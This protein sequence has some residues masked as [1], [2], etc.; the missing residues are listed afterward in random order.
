MPEFG[1]KDKRPRKIYSTGES[2]WYKEKQNMSKSPVSFIPAGHLSYERTLH[3]L[4]MHGDD[5][6]LYYLFL[7]LG[8]TDT[9]EAWGIS[10]DRRT[11]RCAIVDAETGMLVASKFRDEPRLVFEREVGQM[12]LMDEQGRIAFVS[13]DLKFDLG[14][15]IRESTL[16]Q[17]AEEAILTAYEEHLKRI[18]ADKRD[19]LQKALM[20]ELLMTD[21]PRT[22]HTGTVS[23]RV[24]YRDT[25]LV[26]HTERTPST[27]SHHYG[28]CLSEYVFVASVPMAEKPSFIALIM[29]EGIDLE[30]ATLGPEIHLPIGYLIRTDEDGKSKLSPLVVDADRLGP[31]RFDIGS[32]FF[33]KTL[34]IEVKN[35][36]GSS[37][38][39]DGKLP[40]RSLFGH[41]T[42]HSQA[43]LGAL[44]LAKDERYNA[45]MIDI[46]GHFLVE[47]GRII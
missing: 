41:V 9:N 40:T 18:D 43:W 36:L 44:G 7:G 11:L 31:E 32:N 16:L 25:P 14:V 17:K 22:E 2:L 13:E 27:V 20:L 10:E 28:N 42:I 21:Y 5:E 33:G 35:E 3:T 45:A 39:N 12:Q 6:R 19:E 4:A 1:I 34:D 8:R 38:L 26:L 47:T 23:V 46:S 37:S 30:Q 24:D 15:E 29:R